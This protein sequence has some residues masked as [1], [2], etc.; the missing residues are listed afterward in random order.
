MNKGFGFLLLPLVILISCTNKT[1]DKTATANHDSIQKYTTLAG[2][3]TLAFDERIKYN[4]K[5]LGFLDLEKN[6]S[7]KR[8]GL[9]LI[10]F[11]QHIFNKKEESRITGEQL[12][13]LSLEAKD[14]LNI[15]R[16]YRNLGLYSLSISENELA[17]EYF[18]K[19]KKLFYSIGN[20]DY[21]IK[22]MMDI[23]K[24]QS[25]AC[26]FLGSNNTAFETL[27]LTNKYN[28]EKHDFKLKKIIAN[29]L[30]SLKQ[31]DKAIE[32]FIDL[33]ENYSDLNEKHELYIEIAYSHI[34]LKQYDEAYKY[35]RKFLQKKAVIFSKPTNYAQCISLL[36][37]YKTERGQYSDL[38]NLFFVADSIFNA[39]N[40][41]SGRNYNQIYLSN[42]YFKN[43]DT[44]NAVNA[45]KKAF[46]FSKSYKNPSDILKSLNQLILVDEINAKKYAEEYIR[47]ND[48]MQISERNFRDKFARVAFETEKITQQKE[49][50]LKQR[51]IVIIVAFTLFL[52]AILIIIIA[53]QRLKQKELRLKE[54]E[55]KTN[56]NIYQLMLTQEGKEEKVRQIEKKRIG[57]ELHDGILNKLVSTRLNLS[58]LS[59]N[60]DETTVKKC[61]D[62][63]KDIQNIEKEIR[64]LAHDL[65][66][67]ISFDSN[68]FSKLF[69]DFIKEHNQTS[70]T[71]FRMEIDPAIDWNTVSNSSKMNLY[72]VI[73]EASQNIIKH[74]NAK[75]A[76]ITILLNGDK[77]SLS[78]ADDGIGLNPSASENGIGLKNMKYR[79]KLLKGK[80]KINSK[81][82]SGTSIIVTIPLTD[83]N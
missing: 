34:D 55:Q 76:K 9:Y 70:S 62:H 67:K 27:A 11:R 54:T 60:R 15:G 28:Y 48:S 30:S 17:I 33:N 39:T 44:L 66:Q 68:S 53:R 58:I 61:L 50:A 25:Y 29:N 81:P 24:T 37:L 5:A 38:P 31:N 20:I 57:L 45:A 13:T 2:N 10:S 51:S 47:I 71:C 3:D 4:D 83:I 36:G 14:T 42:F 22:V 1:T 46:E 18:F 63:I 75:N 64:N 78:I 6:D 56:E 52:I 73:Q 21:I 35:L 41:L 49:T 80:F 59:I 69:S 8:N 40:S 12:M 77:L 32:Y 19:A 43:K 82:N 7:I 72:R 79:I 26:D 23:A 65:N 74:A 16:A